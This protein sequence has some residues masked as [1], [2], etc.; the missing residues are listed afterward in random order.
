MTFSCDNEFHKLDF[1]HQ[2]IRHSPERCSGMLRRFPDS[3]HRQ[4][5]NNRLPVHVA[6]K[7]GMEWSMDLAFMITANLFQLKSVDPVSKLPAFAL[8]ASYCD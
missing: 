4:D 3:I 7:S 2:I 1:L 8:A 5:E 6:L